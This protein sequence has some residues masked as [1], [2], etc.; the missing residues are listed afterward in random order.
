MYNNCE[1][2]SD[3]MLLNCYINGG[4]DMISVLTEIAARWSAKHSAKNTPIAPKIQASQCAAIQKGITLHYI[5]EN[6]R[7]ICKCIVTDVQ[8][9][10]N[11]IT[12]FTV[13]YP[14][15]NESETYS[16]DIIG[17]LFFLSKN[18]MPAI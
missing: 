4:N 6:D 17:R 15:T 13:S 3:D 12:E 2:W 8:R 9:K 7:T 1:S 10:N 5:D 18:D 16:G 14:E 11:T